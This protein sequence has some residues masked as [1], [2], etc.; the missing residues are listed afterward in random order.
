V[1]N[2]ITCK[3]SGESRSA[4]E[5]VW[6]QR[7]GLEIPCMYDVFVKKELEGKKSL[8]EKVKEKLCSLE[9]NAPAKVTHPPCPDPPNIGGDWFWIAYKN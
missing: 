5:G 8:K 7:A 1:T 9:H 4:P 3:I 6:V 2:Y